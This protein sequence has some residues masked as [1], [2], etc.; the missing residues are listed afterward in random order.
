MDQFET[1]IKELGYTE[2]YKDYFKSPDGEIVHLD[3]LFNRW[4][5]A[6]LATQWEHV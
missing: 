3:T 1:Y 6:E 4:Q 5:E 2:V